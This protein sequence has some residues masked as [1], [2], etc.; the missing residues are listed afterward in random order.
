MVG[1]GAI[2]ID[3]A[4]FIILGSNIGTCVTAILASI[5]TSTNAKR[6]AFIHF[7]FNVI[8]TI[9]FTTFIWLFKDFAVTLITSI[10][11]KP[12][13]Q[14]AFFHLIFNLTTT[15][16]LLPFIKQLV[17][18]AERVIKDKEVEVKRTLKYLDERLLKTPSIALAQVKKEVE[19]MASLAKI[20]TYNS[21]NELKTGSGEF[22][23]EIA[24]NEA[25]IDFTNNA[26]TRF[27]IELTSRVDASDE[28]II[29]SYFHVLNDLERIGDHAENFY[30]IGEQMK[31]EELEFS[32]IA[33]SDITNM[34]DEVLAMFET[35]T[36][37]FKTTNFQKLEILNQ[38][39]EIV[40]GLKKSLNQGHVQRLA[41][42][43]CK[44]EL[45]AYFF[46][47]VS[48]LERV[49]DHLVNVGYSIV[50][51]TGSQNA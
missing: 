44:T 3:N 35:A 5:G 19:Y 41:T 6:T 11:V 46:S 12:E 9:I 40:D 2:A 28:K 16:I 26:L 47:T 30:E 24:E 37:A 33:K 39:E 20:N 49:A 25:I 23:A 50:N 27:L 22:S 13:M 8:G 31:D 17:W 48:G 32:D 36:E 51:P 10:P 15:L 34:F 42:G 7:A 4:L 43:C 21:F 38:K 29:G 1:S 45:S 18:L 14:I